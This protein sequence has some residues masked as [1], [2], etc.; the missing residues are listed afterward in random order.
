MQIGGFIADF[1]KGNKSKSVPL[2]IWRGIVLH[3]KIDDFTDKHHA[4]ISAV[5]I[6]KPTFG[7]YSAI[8]VD[9]YFDYFLAKNFKTHTSENLWLFSN[10]FSLNAI[11]HYQHLPKRVKG[12]IFHFAFTNRL[13]KYRTIDGLYD[14]LKIMATYKIKALEPEKC[15]AFLIENQTELYKMFIEL[16]NDLKAFAIKTIQ[17]SD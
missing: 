16:F 15:I 7:R 4:V 2:S 3:R 9:M 12:F 1:I 6:L 10:S 13:Y 8:I 5:N 14:S 17:T 11:I